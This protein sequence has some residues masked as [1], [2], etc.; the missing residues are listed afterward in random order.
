MLPSPLRG[1]SSCC[2]PLLELAGSAHPELQW[3]KAQPCTSSCCSCQLL[4]QPA[5]LLFWNLFNKTLAFKTDPPTVETAAKVLLCESWS[6]KHCWEACSSAWL[7]FACSIL[8]K[9][10]CFLSSAFIAV[11]ACDT[12]LEFQYFSWSLIC[13]VLPL[14]ILKCSPARVISSGIDLT[15]LLVLNASLFAGSLFIVNLSPAFVWSWNMLPFFF[16]FFSFLF[17]TN[18]KMQQKMNN[19]AWIVTLHSWKLGSWKQ[20]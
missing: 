12:T 19:T 9:R 20:I 7:M 15:P 16:F 2:S 11:A 4:A 10:M 3:C 17:F 18:Q 14:L 8:A 13:I 1:A 6:T 5:R